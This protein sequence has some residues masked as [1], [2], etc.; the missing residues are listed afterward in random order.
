MIFIASF[1]YYE[2]ASHSDP[3]KISSRNIALHHFTLQRHR[4]VCSVP[5]RRSRRNSLCKV[6]DLCLRFFT[7]LIVTSQQFIN[8]LPKSSKNLS[9]QLFA[10][11]QFF[12]FL[13]YSFYVSRRYSY[14]NYQFVS[15]RSK[16]VTQKQLRIIHHSKLGGVEVK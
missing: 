5:N 8:L 9:Q 1:C 4:C 6:F 2:F 16:I 12:V 7:S 3:R 10:T 14:D 15:L 13:F 11:I